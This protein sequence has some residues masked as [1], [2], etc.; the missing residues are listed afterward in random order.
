MSLCGPS[1]YMVFAVSFVA[2]GFMLANFVYLIFLVL[3]RAK[4]WDRV[5]CRWEGCEY[6]YCFKGVTYRSSTL[7]VNSEIPFENVD[8]FVRDNYCFV[9]RGNGERSR[10]VNGFVKW[11]NPSAM[12]LGPFLILFFLYIFLPDCFRQRYGEMLA[13]VGLG[14]VFGIAIISSV[15]WSCRARVVG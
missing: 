4:G 11:G 10:H 5:Q 14:V 15:R 8:P 9:K 3:D 7:S 12:A 6:Y 1:E 13:W 2:L